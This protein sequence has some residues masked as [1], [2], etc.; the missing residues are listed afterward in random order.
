[1]ITL[2]GGSAWFVG[3]S[4]RANVEDDRNGHF[5]GVALDLEFYFLP[6]SKILKRFADV[7]DGLDFLTLEVGDDI[8]FK[9]SRGVGGAAEFDGL[10][11]GL[12]VIGG[13][14]DPD[15]A[16]GL[17]TLDIEFEALGGGATCWLGDDAGEESLLGRSEDERGD[18][19]LGS[20]ELDR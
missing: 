15:V 19:R 16:A 5:F 1:M 10:D 9:K 13:E 2:E 14:A 17:I 4:S 3:R 6:W 20:A 11:G 18:F 8:A 7:L 12:D